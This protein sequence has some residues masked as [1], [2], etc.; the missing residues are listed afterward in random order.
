MWSVKRF[1]LCMISTKQNYILSDILEIQYLLEIFLYQILLM[2]IIA[3]FCWIK[4]LHPS[5]EILFA[6]LY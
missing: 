3:Y 2:K 6:L 4:N 5:G 1:P